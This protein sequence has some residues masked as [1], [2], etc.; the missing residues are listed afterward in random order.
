MKPFSRRQFLRQTAAAGSLLLLPAH[1]RAG[2][3]RA[4]GRRLRVA[5]IGV[6]GRGRAHLAGLQDEEFVAFCDVDETCRRRLQQHAGT[7][8]ILA[9]FSAARWFTDYRE[10]LA[11]LGDRL[12]A[13]AIATPDH[14]HYPIALAAITRGLPVCIENPLGRTISEGRA[15]AAAAAQ[16]GVVTQVITPGHVG[17]NTRRIRELVRAGV[18]GEVRTIHVWPGRARAP[19]VAPAAADLDASA[20]AIPAGFHWDLWLGPAPARPYH[21]A[22]APGPWRRWMD[23]GVGPLCEQGGDTL[24]AAV[25]ALELGAPRALVA[26]ASR[27]RAG[28]W[29]ETAAVDY[30]FPANTWR[31][32]VQVQWFENPAAGTTSARNHAGGGLIYGREGILRVSATGVELL[33]EPGRP[34]PTPSRASERGDLWREWTE[35]IRG[36]PACSGNFAVAAPRT[37]IALLGAVAVRAGARLEWD[38]V[39]RRFPNFSEADALLGPG[40]DYRP[41]WGV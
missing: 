34:V 4:T 39:G 22:V 1:L 30:D 17:E 15:L 38:A 5:L 6:G 2:N 37:E 12:D 13:V 41:G 27:A 16:A 26:A 3:P 29:P 31:G 33:R 24:A 28:C 9:R 18:I 14:T 11:A 35:A 36:G 7:A 40:Y 19:Q 8:A 25:G 20:E 23:Y 32:P 21:A 10:M